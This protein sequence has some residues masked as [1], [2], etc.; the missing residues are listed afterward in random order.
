[1]LYLTLLWAV[2]HS[3]LGQ[4]VAI[5][6]IGGAAAMALMVSPRIWRGAVMVCMDTPSCLVGQNDPLIGR[7]CESRASA[8]FPDLFATGKSSALL[9]R[10]QRLESTTILPNAFNA[11]R[12]QASLRVYS[13]AASLDHRAMANPQQR[14]RP[15]ANSCTHFTL[16]SS[17]DLSS[18]SSSSSPHPSLLSNRTKPLFYSPRAVNSPKHHPSSPLPSAYPPTMAPPST[19]RHRRPNT[20]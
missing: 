20:K 10:S 7:S 13:G 1:M 19:P 3:L 16:S 4:V 2:L 6:E 8:T 18:S 9:Q 5:S 11:P 17:S 12:Q 14:T 15:I